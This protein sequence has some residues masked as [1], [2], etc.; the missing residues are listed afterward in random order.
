MKIWTQ[1]LTFILSFSG[2]ELTQLTQLGE[3]KTFK[4]PVSAKDTTDDFELG[5]SR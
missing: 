5:S 4:A 3:I 2:P 1:T